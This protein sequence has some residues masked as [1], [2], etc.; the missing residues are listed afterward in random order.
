[1]PYEAKCKC[2]YLAKS[3]MFL[4]GKLKTITPIQKCVFERHEGAKIY[5]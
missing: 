1:M 4:N 2:I 5:S 3:V